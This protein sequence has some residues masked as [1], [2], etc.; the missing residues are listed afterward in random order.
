MGFVHPKTN[1]DLWVKEGDDHREFI[2]VFV[3][4]VLAFS[5]DP[6]SIFE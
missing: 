1:P 3:D 4:D 2:G 6:K 5:T